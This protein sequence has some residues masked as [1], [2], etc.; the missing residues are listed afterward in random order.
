MN[1]AIPALAKSSAAFK[2]RMAVL[3]SSLPCL[4]FIYARR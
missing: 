3:D 1:F 4:V 2:D